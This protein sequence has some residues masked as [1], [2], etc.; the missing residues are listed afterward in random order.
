MYHSLKFF[1]IL[2]SNFLKFTY[3]S[4]SPANVSLCH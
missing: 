4:S 3:I 2:Y 1:Q